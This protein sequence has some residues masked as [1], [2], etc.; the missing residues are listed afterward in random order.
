MTERYDHTKLPHWLVDGKRY[1]NQL[2]ALKAI[3]SPGPRQEYRFVA[4]EDQYDSVDWTREPDE[5]FQELCVQQAQYIRDKYKKVKLLFTAG[6]DSG[7]IFRTFKENNI[8]IDEL[9]LIKHR[10]KLRIYE[11]DHLVYPLALQLTRD[12]PNTKVVEWITS[13][14]DFEQSYANDYCFENDFVSLQNGVYQPA[15]YQELIPRHDPDHGKDVAYIVGLEKPRLLIEE[16]EWRCAT[17][18]VVLM[19]H[20]CNIGNMEYFYYAPNNPKIMVKQ[21]W[22]LINHIE[23][24]HP[25]WSPAEIHKFINTSRHDRYD[26]LC[27]TLGRGPAMIWEVGNGY[28]KT[29]NGSNPYVQENMRLAADEQWK[30]Y[31]N[32]RVIMDDLQRNWSHMMNENRVELGTIGVWG[33]KYYIKQHKQGVEN[34]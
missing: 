13:P 7:H 10:T 20:N 33:K 11:H 4:W 21:C 16:G 27:L 6:R 1:Y 30:S 26:E 12:M 29:S 25:D 3:Y 31:K 34:A 15:H 24:N 17:L 8:L 2:Q 14:E 22:M 28:N 19:A 5:S 32:F 23:K 18:D 9:V